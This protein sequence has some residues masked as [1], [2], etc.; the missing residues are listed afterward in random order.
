MAR[1]RIVT[2]L[3]VATIG[4]V[5][6]AT[7][8]SAAPGTP[9]APGVGDPY[10]PNAGN[11]GY[12]VAHYG[13]ALRWAPANGDPSQGVLSGTALITATATQNLSQFDL[14]LRGLTVSSLRVNGAKAA[15]TRSGQELVITPKQT[16]RKNLPF[17][18]TVVYSGVPETITDDDG[19][20]DG[21]I[22]TDDGVFVAN[23]PQ[24]SPSWYP[25]S[26]HPSDKAR[27]T[28]SMTVPTGLTAVGNGSLLGSFASNGA[29]TF[30]WNEYRPMAPYLATIT[31]GPF[32]VARST[33]PDGIP[34]YVAVDAREAAASAPVVAKIP[35]ILTWEQSVFGPYPF[36]TAGAIIDTAP[37]VGYALETQTKPVF[38]S[39]P[40]ESTMVH[41]L[42]HQWFGDSVSLTTWKDIWLNEGFAT[43]AEWL[44]SEHSGGD[45]AAAKFAA[46]YA[47]PASNDELWNPPSGNPGS[48]GDIFD[49]SVYERG[50]MTLQAL[51]EKIGDEDFFALL[52][53]WTAA[54]KYG[55][56]TTQ[57]FVALAETVSSQQLDQL[58]QTWLYTPGKPAAGSW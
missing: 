34:L 9:G 45:T 38:D 19:A 12:D 26:D 10:F 31:I 1:L 48:G 55:N 27:Y 11:G 3:A 18:V 20:L 46:D 49:T 39:A 35:D 5:L 37:D 52:K 22:P 13:L 43:Y 42:A 51:R 15:Y 2:T 33:T 23:E 30:I 36:E 28:V 44:W 40:D 32:Q 41:E 24:G 53:A 56:A 8:A 25:V 57:Q 50:A 54:Y 7:P 4:T 16:L 17:L 58:F 21:W 47:E 29:T 6:L 14:D